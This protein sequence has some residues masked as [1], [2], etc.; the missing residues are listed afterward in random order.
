MT[1]VSRKCDLCLHLIYYNV[2]VNFQL[3]F[4]NIISVADDRISCQQCGDIFSCI[5]I[6]ISLLSTI[7]LAIISL[8]PI[9][10]KISFLVFVKFDDLT[11]RQSMKVKE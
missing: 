9:V 3:E 1:R 5:F 4:N 11:L 10:F 8:C 6:F 2:K 7:L